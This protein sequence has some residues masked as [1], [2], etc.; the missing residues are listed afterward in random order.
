MYR[1]FLQEM[2]EECPGIRY[3]YRFYRPPLPF[4]LPKGQAIMAFM[5]S[6]LAEPRGVLVGFW[7]DRFVLCEP[8]VLDCGNVA[9]VGYKAWRDE[10]DERRLIVHNPPPNR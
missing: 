10:I 9:T 3:A 1:D 7:S 8:F 5:M 2:R 6:K 4:Q